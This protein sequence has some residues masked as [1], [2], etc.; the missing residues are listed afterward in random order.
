MHVCAKLCKGRESIIFSERCALDEIQIRPRAFDTDL[1]FPIAMGNDGVHGRKRKKIGERPA[2]AI[3]VPGIFTKSQKRLPDADRAKK[4]IRDSDIASRCDNFSAL[5]RL[6]ILI[7]D[8][9]D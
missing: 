8:N 3:F 2:Q 1:D 9:S 5:K 6:R 4:R 7:D